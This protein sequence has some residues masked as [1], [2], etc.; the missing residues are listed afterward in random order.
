MPRHV[1]RVVFD[2]NVFIQAFLNPQG[3]SGQCFQIARDRLISVFVSKQ[4]IRE[5]KKVLERP[6]IRSIVKLN[7]DEQRDRFLE[8][9]RTS[10]YRS[11]E[12][13]QSFG[14]LRDPKDEMIIDLAIGCN[15]DFVVSRDNDLL[16]LMT[17]VDDASKQF[18][19]KFRELRIIQPNDFLQM[20][21][22]TR[23]DT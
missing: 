9:M 20:I 10:V 15:A 22:E 23:I 3:P 11:T 17:D 19:Q 16:D 2:T 8:E 21:A 7:Y 6:A 14:L 12:V 5:L 18:R 1:F 4:T 13:T